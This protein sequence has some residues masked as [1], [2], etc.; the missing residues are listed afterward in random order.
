ML[1]KHHLS[2]LHQEEAELAVVPSARVPYS[3]QDKGD[4]KQQTQGKEEDVCPNLCTIQS[5]GR[6]AA[7]RSE[8]MLLP[9]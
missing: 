8:A 9:E 1:R 3:P 2:T 4:Q 7:C 5:R 6:H